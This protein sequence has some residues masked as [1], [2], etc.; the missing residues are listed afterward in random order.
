VPAFGRPSHFYWDTTIDDFLGAHAF[1]F[2]K[3]QIPTIATLLDN[4]DMLVPSVEARAVLD[5][6]YSSFSRLLA[7]ERF[8]YFRLTR[9]TVLVMADSLAQWAADRA[10][11][12]WLSFAQTTRVFCV[13]GNTVR[14]MIE[15]GQLEIKPSKGGKETKILRSSIVRMLGEGGRLL[16]TFIEPEAWIARRLSRAEAMLSVNEITDER[17]MRYPL[18]RAIVE[19]EQIPHIHTV[20]GTVLVPVSEVDAHFRWSFKQIAQLFAVST[21]TA[22]SWVTNRFLCDRHPERSAGLCPT[23]EC[24]VAYIAA[25]ANMPAAASG[26]LTIRVAGRVDLVSGEELGDLLIG[27]DAAHAEEL[28][29]SGAIMG[30]LLPPYKGRRELRFLTT[31]VAAFIRLW[32]R[33]LGGGDY[34]R[35]LSEGR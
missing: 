5:V 14:R 32:E 16:P 21:A 10:R 19:T 15:A 11:T 4:P 34:H 1:G 6:T 30:V 18:A 25:N 35:P 33:R 8:A 23:Q 13:T 28:W 31:E 3:R 12:D 20:G 17:N 7:A 27:A 9:S 29:A 26:W 22:R 2:G 24:L